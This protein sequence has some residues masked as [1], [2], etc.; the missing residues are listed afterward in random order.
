MDVHRVLGPGL[1]ENAYRSALLH[2]LALS[3][4]CAQREVPIPF[5]YKGALLDC[6]YRADIVVEQKVL[7]ELKTVEQIAPIHVA[8]TLTYLRLSKLRVGLI[9]N[10][11]AV[12]LRNGLKRLVL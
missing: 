7:L 5:R 2:E 6:A 11:H 1:L 10:F 4:L 8:Q 12:H 9:L 3:G